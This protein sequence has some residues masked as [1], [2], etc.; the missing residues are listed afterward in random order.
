MRVT[1]VTVIAVIV[2]TLLLGAVSPILAAERQI[3]IS[4]LHSQFAPEKGKNGKQP[5][6]QARTQIIHGTVQ[7]VGS[8]YIKVNGKSITI[9]DRTEI[10]W[11]GRGEVTLSDIEPGLRLAIL[12]YQTEGGEL[13]ARRIMVIPVKPGQP[14]KYQHHVG[15]VISYNPGSNATNGSITIKNKQGETFTF[16]IV[17]G[18]FKILPPG[19]AAP[20]E[21]DW[22]TVISH[23]DPVQPD[24]LIAL[25]V[26]VHPR[27]PVGLLI[28]FLESISGIIQ[29]SDSTI[30]VNVTP[31]LTLNYDQS[32]IFVLRGVPS[33][34]GQTATVFYETEADGT[35]KTKFVLVGIDLP[36]VMARIRERLQIQSN[37][38]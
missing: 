10:R 24:Q 22:V 14:L 27:K 32:T 20:Q 18:R 35:K 13:V 38:P 36:G 12:A 25:G 23:R 6:F 34:D 33:A 26:V 30:T 9:T 4:Q 17:D 11:A 5:W 1:K 2:G 37:L 15:E 7:E 31:P 28:G 16:T 3:V 8:D 19:H 29:I 21:G